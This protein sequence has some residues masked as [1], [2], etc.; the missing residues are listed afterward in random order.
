MSS[1]MLLAVKEEAFDLADK[2]VV[3]N[4]GKIEQI[5]TPDEIRKDPATPF[6]MYFIGDIDSLPAKSLFIR[7]M[8]FKTEK[9]MVMLRPEDIRVSN[10]QQS[11]YYCPATV[12]DRYDMGFIVKYII[13][14][15][16]EETVSIFAT[17]EEAA[18]TKSFPVLGRV[19]V[20]VDPEK[21]MGFN[22]EEIE[23]FR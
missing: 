14:F 4:R 1:P 21:M 7:R 8:K 9:S 2:V 15:D 23:Y 10:E 12:A 22:E 16:D 11:E 19:F 5:G 18:T 20:S 3:F 13:R 6:V 17:R